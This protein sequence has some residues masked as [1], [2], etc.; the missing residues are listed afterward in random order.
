M[1]T[2]LVEELRAADEAILRWHQAG[3]DGQATGEGTYH[4]APSTGGSLAEAGG[5]VWMRKH[6]HSP[7][8]DPVAVLARVDPSRAEPIGVMEALIYIADPN[9]NA[10]AVAE[11]AIGA[12]GSV[13][14]TL[15]AHVDEVS[16][17]LGVEQRT[18]HVL[19]AIYA[20]M[21]SVLREPLTERVSISSSHALLDYVSTTLK[22]EKIEMLRVLYLDRKNG[23]L[24]DEPTQRGT[25]DHVP[26]YPREVVRRALEH[27]ASAVILVHNH[28]S[29]D[30]SPSRADITM[31]RE[32]Q[33][34]LHTLGMVLHDHIIVGRNRTLS[35]RSEGHL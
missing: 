31:G 29:G 25:I 35:M 11:R 10:R 5:V 3:S 22:H 14:A 9:V 6:R 1:K 33:R 23:L 27:G 32:V 16:S 8:S 34:A 4:I 24:V 28:P 18:A 20:G 15:A 12:F 2:D 13:G 30:P 19:K 21:C 17:A 7:D 26:L